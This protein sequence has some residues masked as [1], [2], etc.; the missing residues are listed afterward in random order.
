[1]W[2]VVYMNAADIKRYVIYTA[3][4]ML[5]LITLGQTCFHAI[6]VHRIDQIGEQCEWNDK[7]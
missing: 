4:V 3:I 7:R 6:L 5:L 1:M 2:W